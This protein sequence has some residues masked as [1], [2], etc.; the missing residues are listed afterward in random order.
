VKAGKEHMGANDGRIKASAA[1]MQALGIR[2]DTFH[3]DWPS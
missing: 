1:E 3:P 2:G